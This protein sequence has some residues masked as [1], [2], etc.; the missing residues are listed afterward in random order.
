MM[1]RVLSFSGPTI[2]L[3]VGADR[4][5]GCLCLRVGFFLADSGPECD[6]HTYDGGEHCHQ[7]QHSAPTYYASI[8]DWYKWVPF[9][10]LILNLLFYRSR[11]YNHTTSDV[12]RW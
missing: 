1:Q 2:L 4:L 9:F 3:S 11:S 5:P 8:D 7:Q 10:R 12:V 6:G